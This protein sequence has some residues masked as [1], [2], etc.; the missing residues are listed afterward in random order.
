[1]KCITY[2]LTV[3]SYAGLPIIDTD[4]I[5]VINTVQAIKYG[6]FTNAL[7]PKTT[8]FV[9]STYTQIISTST[10]KMVL[11]SYG[12]FMSFAHFFWFSVVS[13]FFSTITVRQKLLAQQGI[14][15]KII[16]AVLSLLGTALLF[17]RI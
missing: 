7:N 17:S 9:V 5:T 4:S 12:F 11:I 3:Y 2:Q 15:N 13:I 6:F 8:L 10:P 1:M 14:M 16:G